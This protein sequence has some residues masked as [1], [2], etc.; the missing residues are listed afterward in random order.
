M[1]LIPG[2]QLRDAS[3]A[4][5]GRGNVEASIVHLHMPVVLLPGKKGH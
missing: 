4:L 2:R 5:A 1:S 3:S